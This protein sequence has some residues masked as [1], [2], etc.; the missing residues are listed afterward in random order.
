MTGIDEVVVLPAKVQVQG[1]CSD[2]FAPVR[3]AFT[4]NLETGQDIGASVAV[5]VDGRCVVDLWGGCHES[6]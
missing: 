1:T 5:F 6:A 4:H 2:E 3:A